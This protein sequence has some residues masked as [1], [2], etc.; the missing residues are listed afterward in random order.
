VLRTYLVVDHLHSVHWMHRPISAVALGCA[1]IVACAGAVRAVESQPVLLPTQPVRFARIPPE[2]IPLPPITGAEI[3]HAMTLA[4]AESM[5]MANHPA[6]RE[7]GGMI[8]AARGQWVQVGLRPNPQ[9]G[10]MGDEIG[11][12]GRAGMQGGFISQEFVTAG[13][14]GLSRAVANREVS[15]AQERLERTRRQVITTVRIYYYELLAAER[16]VAFADQLQRIGAHALEASQLRL[17]ALEGTQSSVLQSQVEADSAVLLLDQATYRRDAARRRLASVLGL[18]A[19][20]PPPL[21]DTLSDQLPALDW[22]TIKSRT[23]AENP[24]LSELRFNVDRAKWAVQRANAGRIPNVTLLSGAQYDNASEFAMANLQLSVP[25]PIFDRN[26]GGIAQAVG[27]L[28]SAQAALDGRELALTQQLAAAMSDYNTSTRRVAK[29]SE[30]ILPAARESFDL[31]SKAYEQG[32]L[33]YLDLLNT[34]RTYTEK[35]LAYLADLGAAWTKWAEIDGLL[36]GPLP[37]TGN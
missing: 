29:Y 37:T 26:Q 20:D 21:E 25:M 30:S 7:A 14:L 27:Q 1:A 36:V 17:K 28:T 8:N 33:E 23:L 32:E 19:A 16:S 15:A 9:L 10:Y 4:D 34:Q 6:M 3:R 2:P 31:T 5:A 13:K 18:D 12:E 35:N 11:D 22:E 24:E